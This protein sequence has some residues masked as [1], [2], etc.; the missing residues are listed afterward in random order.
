MSARVPP[1]LPRPGDDPWR[2]S[3][4]PAL[5]RPTLPPDLG[6][7]AKGLGWLAVQGFFGFILVTTLLALFIV[8]LALDWPPAAWLIGITLLLALLGVVRTAVQGRRL[9]APAPEVPLAQATPDDDEARLLRL[10]RSGERALPPA[11]RPA[12][13]AAVISTRDALRLTS[14]DEALGRDAFDARQAAREDLPELLHTYRATP[15]TPEAERLLVSQLD[16]IGR[17]MGE[18]VHERRGQHTR[19]LE[20]QRRYL[21]SK[22]GDERG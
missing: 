4:R 2:P 14:G 16:L 7:R 17:R 15:R 3:T 22:Y 6:R 18:V 10:L 20:A 21:E 13:H 9:L 5:P 8:L 19:T 11:A 12:F 1:R